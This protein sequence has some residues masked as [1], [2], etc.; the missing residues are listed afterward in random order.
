MPET[1]RY[2]DAPAAAGQPWQPLSAVAAAFGGSTA[3]ACS[4]AS[5]LRSARR[6]ARAL[7]AGQ[8]RRVGPAWEVHRAARLPDGLTVAAFLAVGQRPQLAGHAA[9][10]GFETWTDKQ[11]QRFLAT[12]ELLDHWRQ[13]QRAHAGAQKALIAGFAAAYGPWAHSVGLRVSLS[14]LKDYARRVTPSSERFDGNVDGRGRK[15]AP[16]EISNRKSE[17][18]AQRRVSNLESQI[19][20]PSAPA[21]AGH[22]PP[23][24][25]TDDA[26]SCDASDAGPDGW[27]RLLC[28]LYLAGNQHSVAS[29]YNYVQALNWEQQRGWR[30]PALRTVQRRVETEIAHGVKVLCRQGE[31]AF[32]AQCAPKLRRDYEQVAA[33]DWWCLDGRTLDIMCRVPDSR[34]EWRRA[35]LVVTGVLDMRSR[36]LACDVRAT[37]HADGILSGI[38]RALRA[39]GVPTDVIAD[40]GE[41]YKAAV[42]SPRGTAW[43]RATLADP[44]IGSVFAELGVTLHN[45]LPYHAWAKPIESIWRKFKDGFDRWFGSFWGGSPAERPHGAERWTQRR[46][47]S[48]PTED[49]LC[50]AL[51][52]YLDEYDNS[53]QSGQGTAGYPPRIAMQ[54]FR[55]ERRQVAHPDV[56]DYLCA[57]KRGPVRVTRDGVRHRHVLYRLPP[58]QHAH[59]QGKDVWLR[60]DCQR[61]DYVTLCAADGAP[62][63]YATARLPSGTTQD[64]VRAAA[65]E[66]ARYQR[67]VKAYAPARDYLR[68]SSTSQILATKA[69]YAQARAADLER[70]LGP[71]PQP[72]VTLVRPDLAAA[73]ADL[74][75]RS[76]ISNRKS[77][78]CGSGRAVESGSTPRR[79][80]FDELATPVAPAA[81]PSA[82]ERLAAPDWS[83]LYPVD[84]AAA[85]ARDDAPA[86]WSAFEEAG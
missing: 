62:I 59:W 8:A 63:G 54:E 51:A 39:W 50:A 34:S 32:A 80:G 58:E 24:C 3:G 45:S 78:I 57:R 40:N 61:A 12:H 1:A 18:A 46:L 4:L 43:Q 35:R 38:K 27:W 10:P 79:N 71:A 29:A 31:R 19:S 36:R 84:D 44:R 13:W 5:A 82:G 28:D 69:A 64:D 14:A 70:R 33:G 2:V 76:R 21:P 6:W 15:V 60:L 65:K 49:D 26:G 72:D 7:P 83:A 37:E 22:T 20:D 48:L 52:T 55:A 77:Q 86:D 67:V 25:V 16:P 47:L 73:V 53:P 30:I 41:A 81:P 75:A 85:A 56:I 17:I 9:P 11:R 23:V 42:G 66:R 68:E 74:H